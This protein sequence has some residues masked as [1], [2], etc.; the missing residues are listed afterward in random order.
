MFFDN[1][2]CISHTNKNKFG[3]CDDLENKYPA[4]IYHVNQKSWIATVINDNQ[5]TLGFIAID[6]CIPSLG[7]KCDCLLYGDDFL[8]LIELKNRKIGSSD[9]GSEAEE[10]LISTIRMLNANDIDIFL[11]S[12]FNKKKA[13][14][15]NRKKKNFAVIENSRKRSFFIK[16][17]FRLH[18]EAEIRI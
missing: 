12:T 9:W 4:Y 7:K 5:K 10:Q 11:V 15:C 16:T 18:I 2:N 3:I 6:N 1:K 17:G 14:V 13:Y 8:Y